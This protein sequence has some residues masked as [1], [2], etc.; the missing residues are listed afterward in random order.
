MRSL[1][2][3]CCAVA[4]LAAAGAVA[5]HDV[6]RAGAPAWVSRSIPEARGEIKVGA[7]GKRIAVRY[8]GWSTR[9]FGAFRTYAYDDTRPEPAPQLGALPAGA[10][11]DPKRGRALFLDRQGGARTG[12]PLVPRADGLPPGSAGP[13][14]PAV[15]EPPQPR[16][17][18]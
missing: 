9:D 16:A 15:G 6:V 14:L 18:T 7:D 17:R 8:K 1:T 2:R 13:P 10:V 3:I 12:G 4:I 11:G 5:T